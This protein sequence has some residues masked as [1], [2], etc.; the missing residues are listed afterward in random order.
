[1]NGIPRSPSGECKV[2]VWNLSRPAWPELN[3]LASTEN[4]FQTPC[5]DFAVLLFFGNGLLDSRVWGSQSNGVEAEPGGMISACCD[6]SRATHA[7]RCEMLMRRPTAAVPSVSHATG[8]ASTTNHWNSHVSI[9]ATAEALGQPAPRATRD[10]TSPVIER[11][12]CCARSSGLF[13]FLH[14]CLPT[15]HT[16][17]PCTTGKCPACARRLHSMPVH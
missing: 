7:A 4:R 14:P 10:V 2:G 5:F 17:C 11:N 15:R 3:Q 12:T 13:L 6:S 8:R 16:L 9:G 1:M